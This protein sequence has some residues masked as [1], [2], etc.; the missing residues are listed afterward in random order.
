MPPFTRALLVVDVQN[1]FCPGGALP[2]AEGDRVVPVINEVAARFAARGEP[3]FVSRDWHPQDTNHFQDYGGPW[4]VHCVADTPGAE[5][6]PDLVLPDGAVIV[7]KGEDPADHGYSAFEGRTPDGTGLGD[8]LDRLGV[9]TLVVAG[10]ATDYCVK[11]SVLDAREHGLEVMVLA[12]AVR[13]VNVQPGDDARAIEAM[14]QAGA[15]VLSSEE[16]EDRPEP[17]PR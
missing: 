7:S 15:A 11:Q 6:H 13:A 12:D 3:V 5:F 2:V 9:R 4:P 8:A 1:D 16:L 10:L 17:G 14:R